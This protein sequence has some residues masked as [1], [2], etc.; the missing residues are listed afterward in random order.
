M[1][2]Q[3]EKS[4]LATVSY[5]DIFD[6][7][8]TA[9]EIWKWLYDQE[10]NLPAV[11]FFQVY[12]LLMAKDSVLAG[13]LESKNGF[14]FLPNRA[15]I[16]DLRLENNK[17]AIRKYKKALRFAKLL[18][19]CPYIKMI[20]IC[21]SL[22]FA[23]AGDY[24]D[25]DFFIIAKKK[26]IWLARFCANFLPKFLGIRPT[27]GDTQDKFCFTFFVTEDN[28]DLQRLQ[29]DQDDIYLKFW[30]TQIQPVY[31]PAGC[32]QKLLSANNWA[33][34]CFPNFFPVELSFHRQVKNGWL[35]KFFRELI[36]FFSVGPLGW[37]QEKLAKSLQLKIL[38]RYLRK[39]ANQ[40]NKVVIN[41]QVLK[42][43]DNDRRLK[44]KEMFE[45]R[46]RQVVSN[47]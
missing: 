2:Q 24:S 33:L 29:I 5:Y 46:M 3:L 42:F 9:W 40:G 10:K 47:G 18:K 27:H 8:L 28:L 36:K 38:P 21:N 22:S 7:P 17:V 11:S 34:K 32:Y 31:D 19:L 23:N 41:D 14:Y 12:S 26:R 45:E 39:M 30:L 1:L 15:R 4:I 25:I 6:Y 43:H 20:A 16:V 35:S 37:L 13:R 44:Y